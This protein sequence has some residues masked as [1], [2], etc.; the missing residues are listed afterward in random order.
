MTPTFTA[1]EKH[2]AVMREIALRKSVYPHKVKT[3]GMSQREADKQIAVME[4]IA[5]DYLEPPP[6]FSVSALKVGI[7]PEP[8]V[9]ADISR[10]GVTLRDG[11]P[12]ED[13]GKDELLVL[14]RDLI[15]LVRGE[16]R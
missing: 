5:A 6:L 16:L 13:L 11:R 12:L 7:A 1:T 14:V 9:I 3:G 4:A 10:Q 15:Y 2:H 8:H